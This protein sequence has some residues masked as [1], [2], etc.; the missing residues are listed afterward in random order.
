MLIFWHDEMDVSGLLVKCKSLEKPGLIILK[1]SNSFCHSVQMPPFP[2]VFWTLKW[3]V[4]NWMDSVI[5]FLLIQLR[6][7]W[8]KACLSGWVIAVYKSDVEENV[9]ANI[10][11][12][13]AIR[14]RLA[15]EYFEFIIQY[16][17]LDIMMMITFWIFHFIRALISAQNVFI[18]CW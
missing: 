15:A 5:P 16:L 18:I 14:L 13:V 17:Y 11:L 9:F 7:K 3:S 10:M 4:L 12:D 6:K 8:L 1:L 2:V